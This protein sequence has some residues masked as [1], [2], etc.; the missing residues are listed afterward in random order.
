MSRAHGV[1]PMTSSAI[2]DVTACHCCT[3]SKCVFYQP[4]KTALVCAVRERAPVCARVSTRKVFSIQRKV[5]RF[6]LV[7]LLNSNSF[8]RIIPFSPSAHFSR[9]CLSINSRVCVSFFPSSILY[10]ILFVMLIF[11]FCFFFRRKVRSA[12]FSLFY[13]HSSH[14]L[15]IYLDAPWCKFLNCQIFRRV[16]T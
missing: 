1:F 4:Y 9:F 6:W 13:S 14:I 3:W 2:A 7:I 16:S 8:L 15:F 5:F 12:F 11:G 10:E